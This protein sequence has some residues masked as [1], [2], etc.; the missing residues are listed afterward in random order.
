MKNNWKNKWDA[1]E[2]CKQNNAEN[3]VLS[4]VCKNLAAQGY[5]IFDIQ[6]GM[7]EYVSVCLRKRKGLTA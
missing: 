2:W 7:A 3:M 5:A 6:E 4:D 1:Y